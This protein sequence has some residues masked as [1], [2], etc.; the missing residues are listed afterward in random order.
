MIDEHELSEVMTE[1]GFSKQDMTIL[2]TLV[3]NKSY[4]IASQA[5]NLTEG[6]MKHR[7]FRACRILRTDV[8]GAIFAEDL[9][10][11][12]EAYKMN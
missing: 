8:R 9:L 10:N 5:M 11:K 1:L 6:R 12:F 7:F 4:K 2:R 3:R